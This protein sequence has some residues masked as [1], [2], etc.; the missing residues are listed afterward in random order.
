MSCGGDTEP[1]TP[2]TPTVKNTST[3]KLEK[4]FE[5]I[6]PQASGVTF[7]NTINEDYNHNIL[8]FEYLYN[9][10]GVAIGDLNNDGLPD[11]YFS[12]TFVSNKLYLN[13]GDMKFED[14]TNQAGVAANDGFNWSD[15]GGC[16]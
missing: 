11:I 12:G 2:P 9:G 8:T 10:G 6:S 4:R 16:K 7:S 15:N 5:L 1:V 14:I 3:Q 13:K